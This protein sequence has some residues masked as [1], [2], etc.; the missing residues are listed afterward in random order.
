MHPACDQCWTLEQRKPELVNPNCEPIQDRVGACSRRALCGATSM[1]APVS[2][3]SAVM[4]QPELDAGRQRHPAAEHEVPRALVHG[5]AVGK[6]PRTRGGRPVR[7]R[8]SA[9]AEKRPARAG[10]DPRSR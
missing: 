6:T 5:P 8:R 1:P 9:G 10:V 3:S 2:A 7:C 4:P